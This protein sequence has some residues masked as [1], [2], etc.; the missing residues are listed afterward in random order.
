M[1]ERMFLLATPKEAPMLTL[2]QALAALPLGGNDEVP[3]FLQSDAELTIAYG[4]FHFRIGY[5]S[6]DLAAQE[7]LE[8]AAAYATAHPARDKIRQ[9]Y[10]RYELTSDF[11]PDMDHFNDLLFITEKIES[12]G[13][14]YTF[15][16]QE[17]AF[18]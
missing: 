5:Q 13:E 15:D 2:E 14:V 16:P 18:Q 8:I 10:A 17:E 11:D 7:S 12:L 1:Y 4:D 3:V 6:G 9:T